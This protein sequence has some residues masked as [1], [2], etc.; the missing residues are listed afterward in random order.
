MLRFV[1][2]QFPNVLPR[3]LSICLLQHLMQLL[4]R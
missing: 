4:L 3:L 1:D 2:N